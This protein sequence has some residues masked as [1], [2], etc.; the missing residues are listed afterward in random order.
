MIEGWML[1]ALFVA[2]PLF[3]IV[4]FAFGTYRVNRLAVRGDE[5]ISS[6]K[7]REAV[8]AYRNAYPGMEEIRE[9]RNEQR[10]E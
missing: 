1:L 2:S 8:E 6:K 4:G 7:L 5:Q 9:H 10:G 3:F